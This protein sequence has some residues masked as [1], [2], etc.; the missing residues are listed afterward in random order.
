MTE[1]AAGVAGGGVAA[2]GAALAL[3]DAG[4]APGGVAGGATGACVFSAVAGGAPFSSGCSRTTFAPGPTVAVL[5]FA[6]ASAFAAAICA[7]GT[8]F[9]CSILLAVSTLIGASAAAVPAARAISAGFSAAAAAAAR[10]ASA[11]VSAASSVGL[12]SI[13]APSWPLVFPA[14]V[15]WEI[16]PLAVSAPW[17]LC[18]ARIVVPVGSQTLARP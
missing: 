12:S 18:C 7:A 8:T 6:S 2:G 16:S 17:I 5:Y 10:A 1:G 4:D 3:G 9:P 15:P 14:S 13:S 11:G